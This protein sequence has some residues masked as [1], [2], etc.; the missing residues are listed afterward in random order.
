[1]GELLEKAL[2]FSEKKGYFAK[3]P[4]GEKERTRKAVQKVATSISVPD[5]W[6]VKMV[7][8][9]A[10]GFDSFK[11]TIGFHARGCTGIVQVCRNQ[12]TMD[13]TGYI[14]RVGG[15]GAWKALGPAKQIVAW[16]KEH[17]NYWLKVNKRKPTSLGQFYAVNLYPASVGWIKT[18]KKGVKSETSKIPIPPQAHVLYTDWDNNKKKR[19]GGGFISFASL[20][21][22]LNLHTENMLGVKSN[23]TATVDESSVGSVPGDSNNTP[24]I[25]GNGSGGVALGAIFKG[26]NCPPPPYTIQDRIIYAGCQ[27]KLASAVQAGGNSL[28][29][30]APGSSTVNGEP[31]TPNASPVIEGSINPGGFIYPCK[32]IVNSTF[33]RRSGKHHGGWDI[34]SPNKN[35]IFAVADGKVVATY[36]KCIVGNQRCGLPP[37]SIRGLPGF[38]GY[39]NMVYIDHGGGLYTL[40]GHNT[41]VSATIGQ[42]IKQGQQIAIMGNTGH[43]TG[44]HLH[45]E[46][47]LNGKQ[48]DPKKYYPKKGIDSEI[49]SL[50]P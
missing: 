25:T 37:G 17:Y 12:S 50:Q 23:E 13:D 34:A 26:E 2:D 15:H 14:K 39:G 42:Q 3:H 21:R 19:T 45:F 11:D 9:E 38:Q 41:S 47:R 49:T 20:T 22:G 36:N 46:I 44:P 10:G 31:G 35:G 30:A 27:T 6:I 8:I 5:E 32:G 1:M 43:S 4:A 18:G 16:E 33:K 29:H 48:I 28:G 40:Y 24:A 7:M